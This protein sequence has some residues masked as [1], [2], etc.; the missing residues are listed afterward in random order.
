[1]SPFVFI[2]F[3]IV[4][5]VCGQLLLKN[6]MIRIARLAPGTGGSLPLRMA[7]SPWVVGGLLVYA[8]GV[9][10]WTMALSYLQLSF[11]YPFGSL[12][13]IGILIGSYF[14]FKEPLS[15][16]RLIGIGLIVFGLLLVSQS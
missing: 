1:M 9:L 16:A 2:A 6:G 11:V 13:Y 5:N 15:R 12:G 8:S 14:I 4:G 3:S 10:F 7:R